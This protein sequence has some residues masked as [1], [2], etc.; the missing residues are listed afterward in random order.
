MEDEF[1]FLVREYREKF[2]VGPPVWG[3]SDEEAINQMKKALKTG[4]EMEGFDES[5]LPPDALL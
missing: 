1:N 5:K 3:L 4:R 2:D